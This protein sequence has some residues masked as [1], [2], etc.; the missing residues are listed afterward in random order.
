ME[1]NRKPIAKG[2]TWAGPGWLLLRA[3]ALEAAHSVPPRRF[4][5][6]YADPPFPGERPHR[7]GVALDPR[8]WKNIDAYLDWLRARLAAMR[9][10]LTPSGSLFVHLDWRAVHEVK[11]LLDSLF[12]REA[13]T[14]EIIWSYRTGG[15]GERWLPRKHDTILFYAR[16]RGYKLTP[17][18]ERVALAH[19]YGFKNAAVRADERGYYRIS[20][21]R[22]VWEIPALRANMRE[23]VPYPRQKPLEL[24]RRVIGMATDPGDMVGDFFCGSGT[25]LVAALEMGRRAVGAD[26]SQLALEI[27]FSRLKAVGDRDRE[28]EG[29]ISVAPMRR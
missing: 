27:S 15:V 3:D 19:G 8:A 17:L 28:P 6:I 5:V 2:R 20:R 22:D 14:N 4:D 1:S 12:G 9:D 25:T 29:D 18:W 11:I 16:G 7:P 23:R 26:I 13:F 24:A 21:M 10:L